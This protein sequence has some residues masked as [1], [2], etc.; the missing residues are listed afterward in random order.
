MN[1]E[2]SKIIFNRKLNYE[3]NNNNN[4]NKLIH[5]KQKY[6]IQS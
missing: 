1:F 5:F 3:R 6:K 4:N 2:L